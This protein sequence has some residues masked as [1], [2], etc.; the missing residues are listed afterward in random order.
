MAELF[1]GSI[2]AAAAGAHVGAAQNGSH[3]AGGVGAGVW[4]S[5]KCAEF[6][7]NRIAM[8]IPS[9]AADAVATTPQLSLGNVMTL[10]PSWRVRKITS[11]LA[12]D[13]DNCDKMVLRNQFPVMAALG[14]LR[15]SLAIRL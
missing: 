4:G 2:S 9:T 1:A 8:A 7:S 12:G 6:T 13:R 11:A 15:N 10:V 14:P 5:S 3:D